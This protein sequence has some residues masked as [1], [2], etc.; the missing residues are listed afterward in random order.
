MCWKH[1]CAVMTLVMLATRRGAHPTAKFTDLGLGKA[2]QTTI[3]ESHVAGTMG[4][5]APEVMD[6]EPNTAASDVF[7][8]GLVFFYLLSGGKHALDPRRKRV[9]HLVTLGFPAGAGAVALKKNLAAHMPGA[10]AKSLV[11]WM[12]QSEPEDRP[13]ASEVL[14]HPFFMDEDAKHVSDPAISC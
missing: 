4:W 10:E 1:T 3:T 12:L 14:A 5:Q 13:T 11:A 2:L 7:S 9:V 8:L 6:E